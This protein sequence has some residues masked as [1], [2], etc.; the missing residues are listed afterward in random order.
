MSECVGVS[1]VAKAYLDEYGHLMPL[2]NWNRDVAWLLAFGIVRGGLSEEHWKVI[3]YLRSYYLRFGIVPPIR[4][5]ARDT[6]IRLSRIYRLFPTGVARGACR[7][8]GIPSDVFGHPLAC[9]YP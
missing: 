7:I 8:A 4:K 1:I 5:L 3:E 6:G 2:E 9:L